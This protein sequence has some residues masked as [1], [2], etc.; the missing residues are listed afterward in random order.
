MGIVLI[1]EWA[2]TEAERILD[3]FVSYEG[4]DDLLKLEQ[5][6]A[7]ALCRAYEMGTER[8]KPKQPLRLDEKQ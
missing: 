8:G 2:E 4:S 3:S 7:A 6:I 5:A 1:E